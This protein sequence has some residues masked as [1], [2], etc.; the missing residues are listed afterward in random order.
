MD[1]VLGFL[2]RAN[3]IHQFQFPTSMLQRQR[4]SLSVSLSSIPCFEGSLSL[5]STL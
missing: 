3:P 2:K 5:S 1:W 4:L